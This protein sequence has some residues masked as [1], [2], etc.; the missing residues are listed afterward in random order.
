MPNVGHRRAG[1]LAKAVRI[2]GHRPPVDEREAGRP[3]AFSDDLARPLVPLEEDCHRDL[4]S[5]QA[6][7]DLDEQP[8]AVTAL[9]VGVKAAP[10]GEACQ[11][12]NSERH[13]FMAEIGGGYEAHAAGG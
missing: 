11:R 6:V 5:E 8:R 4:A 13:R 1:T 2:D 7:R 9:A 12:L 10:V 3:D